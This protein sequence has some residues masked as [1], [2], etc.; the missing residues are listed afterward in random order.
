MQKLIPSD[1]YEWKAGVRKNL[2]ILLAVYGLGICLVC[3][4]V[5]IPVAIFITGL[6]VAD[7]F[8][9]GESWPMLLSFEK[10]PEKML[11]YKIRRHF[12]LYAIC[13]LPLIVLFIL[14]HQDLWYIP[15]IEFLSLSS[16]H[17]Y[18]ITVKF[19]CFRIDGN[20]HVN[21]ALYLT[22]IFIGLI[23]VT[24]PFLL[25]ISVYFFQKACTNL[26]PLLYDYN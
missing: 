6:V 9:P 8:I 13:N 18:M 2:F 4:T 5:A 24:T 14:F 16:I 22:G 20:N 11:L 12:L 3:F 15:F 10:A 21:Y 17:I 25:L 7:F 26:K 19:A 23:P 1:L